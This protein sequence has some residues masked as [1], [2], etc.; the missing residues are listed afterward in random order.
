MYDDAYNQKVADTVMA[1][2]KRKALNVD[3]LNGSGISGGQ[4]GSSR[5]HAAELYKQQNQVF[6]SDVKRNL[7][8]PQSVIDERAKY[9]LG[10]GK[11]RGGSGMVGF[12]ERAPL[13]AVEPESVIRQ[14]AGLDLGAGRSSAG[15]KGVLR[16]C[17]GAMLRE[18]F[19]S[20]EI[21][22]GGVTSMMR[23]QLPH[24]MKKMAAQISKALLK[25]RK[26][27]GMSGG[28]KYE[29]DL[30]EDSDDE[31]MEGGAMP[32]HMSGCG[33]MEMEEEAERRVGGRACCA[34]CA[35]CKCGK[36]KSGAGMSGGYGPVA[37]TTE[38]LYGYDNRAQ[39][40]GLR[41][42]PSVNQQPGMR[43]SGTSGGVKLR[44]GKNTDS[45]GKCCFPAG[46]CRGNVKYGGAMQPVSVQELGRSLIPQAQLP[47]GIGGAR[48]CPANYDPVTDP[49]TG[50]V[51][52]NKCE[53]NA[54]KESANAVDPFQSI[55]LGDKMKRG[56][57][58][59]GNLDNYAA[60]SSGS[61]IPELQS[62]KSNIGSGARSARGAMVSKL[63]REK[64]MSL[65]EASRYIKNN[66]GAG[67][68]NS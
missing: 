10:S 9:D 15:L 8:M 18:K 27:R 43:G 25:R 52:S 61:I 48:I 66:K 14:R 33:D 21:G 45:K 38:S 68:G 53:M 20:K 29:I 24:G 67:V 59:R 3:R 19:E 23:G 22:R 7:V 2:S 60:S 16:A 62:R 56:P 12:P 47:S 58:G 40:K 63:M 31:S 35:K 50:R 55:P 41:P 37:P 42:P 57:F 17:G 11:Y 39:P 49:A 51:Y 64:G 34:R 32:L 6:E 30:E 46:R 65:G 44:S 36:G 26:G 5:V 54:A 28:A 4:D 13:R 1:R